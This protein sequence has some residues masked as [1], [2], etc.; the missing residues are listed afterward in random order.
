MIVRH[1]DDLGRFVIPKEMRKEMELKDNDPL[2]IELQGKEIVVRKH[3][4]KCIFCGKNKVF[5]EFNNKRICK[6]CLEELKNE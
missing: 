5:V 4:T 2:E 3:E 1:L 6:K